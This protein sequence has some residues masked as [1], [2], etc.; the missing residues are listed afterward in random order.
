M[1]IRA[2]PASGATDESAEA[3]GRVPS[4]S[5][6]TAELL[7]HAL[8]DAATGFAVVRGCSHLFVFAN[9]AWQTLAGQVPG[10]IVGRTL[11]R[12]SPALATAD[13]LAMLEQ[14]YATGA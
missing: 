10:P 9:S 2:A 1:P 14:V 8:H 5:G 12:A 4:S 6:S 13:H 7:S 3:G 11:H